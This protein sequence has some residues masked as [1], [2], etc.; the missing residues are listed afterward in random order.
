MVDVKEDIRSWKSKGDTAPSAF[1]SHKWPVAGAPYGF[2]G[3]QLHHPGFN[4][5]ILC[6][7]WDG[8]FTA[9]KALCQV[10]AALKN[11]I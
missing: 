7:K 4:P 5:F 3:C 6:T 9:W 10:F 11:R 2:L 8:F 1:V